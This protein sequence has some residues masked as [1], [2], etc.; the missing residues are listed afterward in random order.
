[1]Q[2]SKRVGAPPGDVPAGG[3]PGLPHRECRGRRGGRGA[4]KGSAAG[5]HGARTWEVGAFLLQHRLCL[6][7]ISG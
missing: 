1:M 5:W 7:Y 4:S 3:R 6:G 2:G